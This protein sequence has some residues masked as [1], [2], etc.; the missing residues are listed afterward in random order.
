MQSITTQVC[1]TA[2]DTQPSK[3]NHSHFNVMAPQADSK[4]TIASNTSR[5]KYLEKPED[6]MREQQI[7]DLPPEGQGIWTTDEQRGPAQAAETPRRK[8][9][10]QEPA[11]HGHAQARGGPCPTVLINKALL[12]RSHTHSL[13]CDLWQGCMIMA[14]LGQAAK[15]RP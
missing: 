12:E 13:A 15:P 7:R 10:Q 9:W 4:T 5:S 14:R 8:P 3:R 2:V 1:H 6:A 11:T